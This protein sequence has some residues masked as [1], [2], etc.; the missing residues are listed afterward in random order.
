MAVFDGQA[1][2]ILLVLVF[3]CPL[4]PAGGWCWLKSIECCLQCLGAIVKSARKFAYVPMYLCLLGLLVDGCST[5]ACDYFKEVKEG[6]IQEEAQHA[7]YAF[8]CTS[9]LALLTIVIS[10][11]ST[12][13][14]LQGTAAHDSRM[15]VTGSSVG[16]SEFRKLG[17][18]VVVSEQRERTVYILALPAFYGLMCFLS[19]QQLLMY[20]LGTLDEHW[21]WNTKFKNDQER[22]EFTLD[23]MT[24]YMSAANVF[25][26]FALTFFGMLTMESLRRSSERESTIRMSRRSREQRLQ[27]CIQSWTMSP[28]Y[29]FCGVLCVQSVYRLLHVMTKYFHLLDVCPPALSRSL[30]GLP[31]P[32]EFVVYIAFFT[33]QSIF[34]TLAIMALI[35]IEHV[36]GDDLE[37]VEFTSRGHRRNCK[38]LANLKFWGVKIFVTLEF[39]LD[40]GM[41][42]V[43]MDEFQKK[44]IFTVFMTLISFLVSV[45]HIWAYAPRGRWIVEASASALE[46]E[47]EA[48]AEADDEVE[49]Q[50]RQELGAVSG[51][52]L[53]LASARADAVLALGAACLPAS[54]STSRA[55]PRAAPPAPLQVAGAGASTPRSGTRLG[56]SSSSAFEEHGGLE[57]SSPRSPR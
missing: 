19:A 57:A 15:A 44:L 49:A 37:A 24:F 36:F 14:T 29:M 5:V 26:S 50:R 46:V 38:I 51:P 20:K 39:G 4:I 3:C 21:S 18:V 41:M 10:V 27:G 56:A 55:G 13:K 17:L 48:A 28:I 7:A 11:A 32:D 23:M 1:Q 2:I 25:E 45:L 34:S 43:K 47:A 40:V 9:T 54:S 22:F 31:V 33:L 12:A 35:S 42:M 6:S 8:A 52:T 16:E 53:P 30:A